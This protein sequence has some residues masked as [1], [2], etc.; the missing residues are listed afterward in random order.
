VLGLAE[1]ALQDAQAAQDEARELLGE[2]LRLLR[3]LART[4]RR[5]H[6]PHAN[7]AGVAARRL[8]PGLGPWESVA[9]DE[10]PLQRETLQQIRASLPMLDPSDW[11][12]A[13]GVD[14]GDIRFDRGRRV[15]M[16]EDWRTGLK[17][18]ENRTRAE[19]LRAVTA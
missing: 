18:M 11:E 15:K 9:R 4:D 10:R 7:A 2:F 19:L 3:G 5:A 12:A 6:A 8:G 1:R 16:N 13:S 17:V 14:A